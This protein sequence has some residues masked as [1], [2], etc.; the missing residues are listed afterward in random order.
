MRAEE[1]MLSW[2][3]LEPIL[4]EFKVAIQDCDHEKLRNLLIQIVP[5]F[6]PKCGIEDLLY[7]EDL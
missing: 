4:N 6:K 2:D 7:K 5:G 1:D 3:E